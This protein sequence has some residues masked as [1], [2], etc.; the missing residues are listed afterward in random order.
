MT[1]RTLIRLSKALLSLTVGLLASLIVFNNLTDYW[2]N[3][4]FVAHVMSMDTVFPESKTRRRAV[5]S[6]RLYHLSYAL[7]IAVEGAITWLCSAGGLAMLRALRAD[8]KTFHESKRLTIAG[9]LAALMLWFTAFQGI[10]AE[11]FGM[12][13]SQQW[14]GLAGASRLTQIVSTVLVFVAMKNDE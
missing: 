14:N 1:T 10:A 2:T 8:G 13:M 6:K 11:W 4:H 3:Y 7:I 5:N 9:L 12:W